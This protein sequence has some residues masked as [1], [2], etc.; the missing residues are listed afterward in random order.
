MSLTCYSNLGAG[1]VNLSELLGFN[2][3]AVNC[4]DLASYIQKV[5][6]S[7]QR[8]RQKLSKIEGW[9]HEP[10]TFKSI[11]R[12]LSCFLV[13]PFAVRGDNQENAVSE[14]IHKISRKAVSKASKVNWKTL[15][16]SNGGDR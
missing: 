5:L 8:I 2:L 9:I 12:P 10:N 4:R 1:S 7:F 3:L 14:K 6:S 11:L 16:Q 15:K 13:F